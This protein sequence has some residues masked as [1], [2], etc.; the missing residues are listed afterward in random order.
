MK[1]CKYARK[2]EA[3]FDGEQEATPEL[4][5]HLAACPVCAA[6]LAE[7]KRLREGVCGILKP[8]AVEDPQL[9][10]F[11]AGIR[12]Q[13]DAPPARSRSIWAVTSLVT[14]AM[15]VALATFAMIKGGP[16]PVRATEVEVSTEIEGAEVG[17]YDSDDDS[18]TIWINVA[19]D[20]L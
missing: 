20:D 14:A 1:H 16:D 4:D 19:E 9:P 17:W 3:L 15:V 10:A 6:L 7:L 5:R 13:L 18:I 12:D 8:G 11:M 2:I